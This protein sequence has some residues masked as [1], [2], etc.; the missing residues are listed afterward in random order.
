ML[1]GCPRML[2]AYWAGAGFLLEVGLLW[3]FAHR[4]HP[5]FQ[6]RTEPRSVETC[7]VFPRRNLDKVLLMIA[8][9]LHL[10]S[11]LS[12]IF[13]TF[14]LYTHFYWSWLNCLASWWQMPVFFFSCLQWQVLSLVPVDWSGWSPW[15]GVC[16]DDKLQHAGC[17][18]GRARKDSC[19]WDKIIADQKQGSRHRGYQAQR[20]WNRICKW[21]VLARMSWLVLKTSCNIM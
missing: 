14:D 19:V 11:N 12:V 3:S 18:H 13:I 17:H 15:L 10:I 16:F 2:G 4:S 8:D 9:I 6:A 20:I 7:L 5:I 21:C 1:W